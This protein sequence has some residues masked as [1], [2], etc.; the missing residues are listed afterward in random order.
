MMT[1][2]SSRIVLAM[3]VLLAPACAA[4]HLPDQDLRITTTGPSAKLP[5]DDLWKDFQK[6]PAAARRQYFG[7]A[8]DVS[9]TVVV[10]KPDAANVPVVYF[11][12]VDQRGVRA[13]LLDERATETVKALTVGSRTSL[14]CFCEGLTPTQDLLLKSCIKP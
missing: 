2:Q 12:P 14:R 5:A 3:L 9:G 8:V 10:I 13:R 4:D 1:K 7:K 6:D 11:G